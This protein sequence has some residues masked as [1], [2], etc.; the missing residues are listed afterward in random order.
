MGIQFYVFGFVPILTY[1]KRKSF[2]LYFWKNLKW[3]LILFSMVLFRS[4]GGEGDENLFIKCHAL[5]PICLAAFVVYF[6]L[7]IYVS[8]YLIYGTYL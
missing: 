8:V 4:G 5:Y 1:L 3:S 2:Q 6:S 7:S